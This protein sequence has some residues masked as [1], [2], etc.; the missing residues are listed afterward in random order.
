MLAKILRH[1]A[2]L[3]FKSK[4]VT[5]I[6]KGNYL[7]ESGPRSNENSKLNFCT[8]RILNCEIYKFKIFI[9][10]FYNVE[11]WRKIDFWKL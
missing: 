3:K 6:I 4:K 5:G 1:S 7:I 2:K 10:R 11:C 9:C 8:N